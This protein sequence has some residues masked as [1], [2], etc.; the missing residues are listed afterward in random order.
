MTDPTPTPSRALLIR[1]GAD[2]LA[3]STSHAGLHLSVSNAVRG[4]MV[5][6][7]EP[8]DALTLAR[9]IEKELGEK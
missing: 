6:T 9:W 4:G 5:L 2:A 7:L 1:A 3:C 8:H